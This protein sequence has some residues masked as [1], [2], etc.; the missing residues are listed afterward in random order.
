MY[1]KCPII[2]DNG[3]TSIKSIGECVCSYE[4]KRYC[5]LTS[6]S[7]EWKNYI[8]TFNKEINNANVSDI[9]VAYQRGN[10]NN[11]FSYWGIKAIRN[12]YSKFDIHYKNIEGELLEAIFNDRDITNNSKYLK[13]SFILISCLL[14]IIP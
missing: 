13:V 12:S 9:H 10:Q 8:E 6:S 3:E 7:T 2:V 1:S 5:A 11:I 14:F 4:G